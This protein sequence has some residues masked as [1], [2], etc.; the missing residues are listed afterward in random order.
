MQITIPPTRLASFV[1]KKLRMTL[2]WSRITK[3]IAV[4]GGMF[5]K[6]RRQTL[7]YS[8]K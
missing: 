5:V 3:E 7:L 1:K 8:C 2:D 6:G 4:V